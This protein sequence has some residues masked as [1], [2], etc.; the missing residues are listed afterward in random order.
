MTVER[1][2]VIA[3][4]PIVHRAEQGIEVMRD[5]APGWTPSAETGEPLEIAHTVGDT[6]A[7]AMRLLVEAPPPFGRYYRDDRGQIAIRST[8]RDGQ[9]RP[10]LMRTLEP[11]RAYSLTYAAAVDA[12]SMQWGWQR[13]IFMFALAA[14]QRG[15]MAH[16]C[17]F[18][19]DTGL[20]VLCPGVSGAGKSTLARRLGD[21]GI[22]VLSD[23]RIA[24]TEERSGFVIWGTPWYSSARAVSSAMAPLR[25]I[26]TIRHGGAPMLTPLPAGEVARCLMKTLAFPF[27]DPAGMV[28][29]LGMV[30]RLV[31]AVPAFEYSY[32]ASP[33]GGNALLRLLTA[34]ASLH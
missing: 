34:N 11:G 28:D 25:A 7:G 14:R 29:A 30:D 15:L 6:S 22:P 19:L 24:V 13:T 23:D 31:S 21:A 17:G 16:G 12:L 8:D 32:D 33:D 10:Q 27:W 26:V 20:G 2:T 18:I 5:L 1:T 9:S 4:I 3:G